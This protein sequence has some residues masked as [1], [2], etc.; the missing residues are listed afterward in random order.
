MVL[1]VLVQRALAAGAAVAGQHA[2]AR[3]RRA[4]ARRPH[5]AGSAW[6]APRRRSRPNTRS[7]AASTQSGDRLL[8][9]NRPA[10]GGSAA[11]PGRPPRG[12]AVPRARLRPGRRPRRQP[13]LADPGDL[14]D[15]PGRHDGG[16]GGRGRPL[17]AQAG[18][19]RGEPLHERLPIAH[20]PVDAVVGRR[21]RSSPCSC[22]AG[23]CFVAWRRSGYRAVDG[24]ARA[25]CGWRSSPSSPCCSTSPNGS[26]NSA[27]RRSRRSPCSGTP[28]PAWRPATSSRA[29]QPTSSADDPHAR[30][31]RR[32]T[33]PSSWNK[34]RERMNVV[35]QPFSAAAGRATAPTCTS[36]SPRRPRQIQNLR[37]D[38]AGLRR[39]LERGPAA[40]AGRRRGCGCKGVPV[41]A[42][43]VGSRTRLPDVE[44]LS[45]DV[46]TFGVAGKSVRDPVH[47]R[48]LAAA[49]VRR[50]P[51]R[52]RPPTATR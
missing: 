26:R 25:A 30:R 4:A 36:R 21:S 28:R 50:R 34:L 11:G 10:G 29:D 14:A 48:Q 12:R 22:T 5:R 51:S 38:R 24:A 32:L 46:P 45:L 13:R 35:I 49:R 18:A 9:V 17:P 40:G 27:P 37:G 3:G 43:P 20:V 23:F 44:L 47:D 39:R 8:A 19:C 52:S 42:V 7:T 15:V 41:F 1:Y 6:P 16:D 33:E 2:P 31:S